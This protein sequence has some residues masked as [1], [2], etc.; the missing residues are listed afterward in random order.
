MGFKVVRAAVS[1][2]GGAGASAGNVTIPVPGGAMRLLAYDVVLT[3][4]P[5]TVDV[6]LTAEGDTKTIATL[7]NMTADLPMKQPLEAAVD[8]VGAD[9]ANT[10]NPNLV[11]PIVF[12]DLKVDVAQGDDATD[13]IVVRFLLE[14]L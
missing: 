3:G 8:N 2:T 10:E 6:T 13:A 12:K 7:T 5:V 9:I 11:S 1:T 4:Q 14:T